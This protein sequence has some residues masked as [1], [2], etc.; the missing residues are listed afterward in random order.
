MYPKWKETCDEKKNA[1][2]DVKTGKWQK[3][4][5]EYLVLEKTLN[6]LEKKTSIRS[7]FEI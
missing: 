5:P 1:I 6:K 4:S 7:T 2:R 3:H